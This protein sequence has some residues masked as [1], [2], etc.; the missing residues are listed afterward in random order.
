M[1][2]ARR[3]RGGRTSQQSAAR[4]PRTP[5]TRPQSAS[6]APTAGARVR[7]PLRAP[8]ARPQPSTAGRIGARRR[9]CD[10][11]GACDGAPNDAGKSWATRARGT[12]IMAAAAVAS[13]RTKGPHAVA[14]R[15]HEHTISRVFAPLEATA[16]SGGGVGGDD[17]SGDNDAQALGGQRV[18]LHDENLHQLHGRHCFAPHSPCC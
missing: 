11:A 13:N 12:G 16:A 17:D 6:A 4:S 18:L 2:P 10:S 5:P 7:R 3:P 8:A 14:A 1:P 9:R 15:T